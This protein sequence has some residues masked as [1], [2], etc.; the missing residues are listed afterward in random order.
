M[1]RIP[2]ITTVINNRLKKYTDDVNGEYKARFKSGK[3]NYWWNFH[4]QN[5]LKQ[6]W[7]YNIEIHQIFINFQSAPLIAYEEINYIK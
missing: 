6:A 3:T 4:S 7:G 2:N 1:Y 5:L